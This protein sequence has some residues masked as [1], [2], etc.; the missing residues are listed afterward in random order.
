MM[1]FVDDHSGRLLRIILALVAA[2]ALWWLL[3]DARSAGAYAIL[4]AW[5][6]S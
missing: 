4:N 3:T 2:A 5:T 6:G 1:T